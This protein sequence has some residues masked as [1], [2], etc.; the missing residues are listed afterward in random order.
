MLGLDVHLQSVAARGPV[1]T[2]LTHKQFFPTVLK[3]L[4]QLEFRPRQ[5]AL[6]TSGTLQAG[7]RQREQ[8]Q[9]RTGWAI[10]EPQCPSPA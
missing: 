6:G 4:V 9:V 8:S 2:L 3:S 1:P 7:D 5:E 10:Q